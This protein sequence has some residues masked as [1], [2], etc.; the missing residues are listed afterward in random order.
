ME[1]QNHDAPSGSLPAPVVIR[2]RE[3][4]AADLL[5]RE[6][7]IA[8]RLGSYASSTV[9]GCNTRRYHGLLVA[10][11]APPVGRVVA[12]SQVVERAAV[13]GA[14]FDLATA[15]F[16]GTLHPAGLELLEEFRNDAAATFVYRA[17]AAE[18]VKEVVLADSA[19]AVLLRYTFRGA[20]GRLT[21]RPL[22]ALRDFHQLRRAGEPH[23]MTFQRRDGAVVVQ[24]LRSALPPLCLTAR[25]GEFGPEPAWWYRFLYRVDVAR[26][27]DGCEDLYTPGTF[28]F[29]VPDGGAC[30]FTASV[31]DP[32]AADFAD[33]LQ[34]RRRRLEELAAAAGPDADETTRRLAVAADA[35]L[36]RRKVRGAPNAATILAGYHWFADWGRDAFIAMPGLLLATGRFAEARAVFRAFA[37]QLSEGMVPNRFDDYSAACHYNS[38]DA[39][40]W[41]ILAGERYLRASGD[42]AFWRSRLLPAARAIVQAYH[43]GTRFDIRADADGLLTGGSRQT[44]LTWMD[45]KLGSEVVTPRHGK[46]VEVNALWYNA[47]R[48]LAERCRDSDGEFAELCADRAAV[49]AAAFAKAFWNAAGGCL[50]DCIT[51]DGPDASVRPNQ[52]FAVSLPHSPLPG[53]KQRAVVRVVGEKL[54][55]PLGLRTLSPDDGRYR[56]RYGGSWESRDRAYHQGTVW[57]WLIGPYVEAYLRVEDYRPF[58]VARAAEMLSAFAP[59][60]ERAGVGFIGEIFDGDAPH[61]PRGCIAQAWSVGEVLRAKRLVQELLRTPKQDATG[62]A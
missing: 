20:G 49:I 24:D 46:A 41:F 55:T 42:R 18:V 11:T 36:V 6:W 17:G 4:D 57:A 37:E 59:H 47:H 53:D 48:I 43:D 40:L 23:E 3:H 52:I 22:V 1:T 15:E 60:L 45:A 26:G 14:T 44:Q 38:I 21:L 58:A 27:Q 9:V 7:L 62:D 19:S 10:A 5:G 34:R 32:S 50:Y 35:F 13:G 25:D 61:E 30:Q 33:T 54:L 8:N 2:R 12:L 56:R 39:S 28:V 16:P 31:P 51:P 29:D